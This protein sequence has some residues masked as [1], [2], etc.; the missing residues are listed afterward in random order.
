MTSECNCI[1]ELGGGGGGLQS[2]LKKSISEIKST[3][4]E[5][6]KCILK[7]VNIVDIYALRTKLYRCLVETLDTLIDDY[8]TLFISTA[9][10]QNQKL[11]ILYWWAVKHKSG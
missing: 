2:P 6:K 5:K 9:I 4:F 1:S 3:P 7:W 11:F 8:L 10:C